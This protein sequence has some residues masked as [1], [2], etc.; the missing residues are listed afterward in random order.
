MRMRT[1]KIIL[2]VAVFLTAMLPIS[3]FGA[4]TND[5]KR[6][7][8]AE[9]LEIIK[10]TELIKSGGEAGKRAEL[11]IVFGYNSLGNVTTFVS[12]LNYGPKDGHANATL[13][14]AIDDD[15]L[16][17]KFECSPRASYRQREFNTSEF[18]K[19][20]EDASK[21]V[22]DD[23]DALKFLVKERH[24]PDIHISMSERHAMINI[25][26]R[27]MEPCWNFQA[28]LGQTQDIIVKIEVELRPDGH[29]SWADISN[30]SELQSD[31]LKIAAGESALRAVLNPSC[32]PYKLP[33]DKY[34]VWKDLKLSFNP[35]EMHR[36]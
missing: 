30:R 13:V 31:P 11:P 36:R 22:V 5:S 20:F 3:G 18:A 29:V 27:T 23:M 2:L 10:L 12:A 26:K 32:Q 35:R 21:T 33:G 19:K 6:I 17:L 24:N 25:I 28:G 4:G 15:S 8:Y 9:C 14:V 1:T 16:I 7:N 34:E